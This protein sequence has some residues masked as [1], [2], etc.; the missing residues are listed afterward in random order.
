M[1]NKGLVAEGSDEE[2][3]PARPPAVKRPRERREPSD[4]EDD[5]VVVEEEEGAPPPAKQ[6]RVEREN[7]GQ[8]EPAQ[9]DDDNELLN[10]ERKPLDESFNYDE[11]LQLPGYTNT[12]GGG[13]QHLDISVHREV[14]VS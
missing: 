1:K 6:A 4:Q 10:V 9:Y 7:S 14:G 12:R 8:S 11:L 2:R 5:V 3:R 13:E